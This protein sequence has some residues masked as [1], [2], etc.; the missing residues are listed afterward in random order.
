MEVQES[1]DVLIVRINRLLRLIK[2]LNESI[3]LRKEYND[4]NFM[5]EQDV[6]LK[7]TFEKE[8]FELLAQMK[9][10]LPF[11]KAA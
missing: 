1:Q 6:S 3:D 8:L 11:Q 7:S 10:T 5:I 9:I 4:S 2:N